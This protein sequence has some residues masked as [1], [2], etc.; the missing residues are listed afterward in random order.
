[1]NLELNGTVV[2]VTGASQGIGAGTALTFAAEGARRIHLAARNAEKLARVKADILALAPAAEVVIH[3]IDLSEAGAAERLAAA[4]GEVDILVNNAGAIPG[5][6]LADVDEA[7]WRLAWD[8]KVFGYINLCRAY[9]ARMRAAGGGVIV[10]NIGNGGE[11]LDPNYIAGAAGN[12][13]L[14]AFTRSLGGAS[15]ADRIRVVGVNPGPVATDRITTLLRKRATD[16]YGDDA[17]YLE[18][19]AGFPL[20]RAA[21]VAEIADMI[22]FLGSPRSAYTSGTIVTIDGGISAHRT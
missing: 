15:L 5:G 8:L 20:S 9:Y 19:A 16:A 1:M 18:F 10:N 17:R 2:L 22:V 4:A 21:S 6:S 14:M 13:A 12:A 7:T 3:A 11:T